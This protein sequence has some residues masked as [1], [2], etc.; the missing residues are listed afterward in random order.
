MLHAFLMSNLSDPIQ[1]GRNSSFGT[2]DLREHAGYIVT[3]Y[4]NGTQEHNYG[5]S[6]NTGPYS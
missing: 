3:S 1:D 2:K 4:C 6:R 5:R